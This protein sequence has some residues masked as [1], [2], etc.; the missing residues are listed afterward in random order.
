MTRF[1]IGLAGAITLLGAPV[2]ATARSNLEGR[3]KNGAMEIV[4]GSCGPTLC[5]RV[6]KASEQQR[7]KA[8]RGSG[9]R[10][11]GARVID[12]IEPVGPRTWSADVFVASRNMN[13]RGT[14][15]QVGP[16]RLAVHGCVLAF[17]CKTTHWDRID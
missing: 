5:G 8:R 4:I 1:F 3:W 7:E 2:S 9:T 10:L 13:A 16:D 14:I 15:E 6:L 12:N 17:I 11:L